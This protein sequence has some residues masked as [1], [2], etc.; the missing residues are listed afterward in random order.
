M[1]NI[2]SFFQ[3]KYQQFNILTPE[4]H[5]V[6]GSLFGNLFSQTITE[7]V[8]SSWEFRGQ[9][10]F[11]EVPGL[12]T[13][14]AFSHLG[15]Y[16]YFH[17]K[18]LKKS[19]CFQSGR[20]HG[21]EGL[22][23][24]QV[25]QSVLGP[26]SAGTPCFVLSNISGGLKKELPVGSVIAITDHINLT[27]QS[28]LFGFPEIN[29]FKQN[30]DKSSFFVDMNKAYDAQN[31]SIITKIMKENS[32]KIFKGVYAGVSG[33]QLETPAEVRML[34]QL[35]ADVV[36]M[37]TIWEVIALRYTKTN[38]S[39]FSIVSNPACGVGSSVEINYTAIVK[40]LKNVIQSFVHFAENKP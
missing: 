23:A 22:T 11:S 15:Q 4:I 31:T 37:S 17:H 2:K 16:H 1:V 38:V 8:F 25:A 34:Q 30:G 9:I 6:L 36:G 29:T 40:T 26:R 20:L 19:I 5:F 33:P 28:P 21:Y 27:G 13:T 18:N 32:L 3:S 10:P 39:A 12:K 24:H 14:T 35:G 7:K